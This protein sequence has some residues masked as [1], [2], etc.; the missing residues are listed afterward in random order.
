MGEGRNITA[1]N[2]GGYDYT[3]R[4]EILPMGLFEGKK[5]DYISSDLKRQSKPK[6]AL[7]VTFDYNDRAA[8]Q[9]GQLGSFVYDKDENGEL[10]LAENTLTSLF[11]DF[12][13]KYK[14]VSV[15]GEYA[16]KTGDN[17]STDLSKGYT[18]GSGYTF[19]AGYLFKSNYEIAG[20][21]TSVTPD[22]KA[23]SSLTEQ[24]E[25]TLGLSKYLV[26]HKL[27]IQSDISYFNTP[28]K[29]SKDDI[30]F[31]LQMELQI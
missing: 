30:R 7:G 29:E 13:F 18:T 19:Q 28:D 15:M 21:Y 24:S 11:V 17:T 14:G 10:V 12:M 23:L 3:G 20:R 22:D 4:L 8:R 27:K 2:I 6:L 5:E 25:Y 26:G 1:V 31:R 16:N 9:R